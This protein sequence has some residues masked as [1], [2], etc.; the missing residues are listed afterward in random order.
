MAET[1][2]EVGK[3][4]A[5]LAESIVPDKRAEKEIKAIEKWVIK[6]AMP[7]LHKAATYMYLINH[8]DASVLDAYFIMVK[9]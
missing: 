6:G 7:D 9:G 1:Q 4:L 2:K 3:M 8:P 5:D